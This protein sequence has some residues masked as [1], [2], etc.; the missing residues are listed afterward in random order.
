MRKGNFVRKIRVPVPIGA[1]GDDQT[2][3]NTMPF[4]PRSD[5]QESSACVCDS[6]MAQS[7]VNHT[8]TMSS[9]D[10]KPKEQKATVLAGGAAQP[11]EAAS[12]IGLVS[13]VK[14][15]AGIAGLL[16]AIGTMGAWAV[17]NY[18]NNA[19]MNNLARICKKGDECTFYIRPWSLQDYTLVDVSPAAAG[20]QRQRGEGIQE[21]KR[22]AL[23]GAASPQP[24]A[25]A[26]AV[27]ANVPTRVN[28]EQQGQREGV[29]LMIHVASVKRMTIVI[30]R[31]NH[32]NGMEQALTVN[33]SDPASPF[34]EFVPFE[35]DDHS[36]NVWQLDYPKIGVYDPKAT[37]AMCVE[38]AAFTLS[39]TQGA[40]TF[41]MAMKVSE[42]SPPTF[43]LLRQWQSDQ[44]VFRA[45]FMLDDASGDFERASVFSKILH[46]LACS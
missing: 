36:R 21:V 46:Q 4:G 34:L 40:N 37:T 6:C 23:A 32:I 12:L 42:D 39:Y 29:E 8:V 28:M 18:N 10:R 3:H 26:A 38:K 5:R 25:A 17:H 2:T 35:S 27:A 43:H 44:S 20:D 14:A 22:V 31:R 13:G 24:R 11:S 33:S 41:F 30:K 9:H 15:A 19:L 16:G 7:T 45:L 1:M